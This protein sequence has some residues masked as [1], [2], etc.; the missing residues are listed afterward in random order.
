[1]EALDIQE[2]AEKWKEMLTKLLQPHPKNPNES[3]LTRKVNKQ[4]LGTLYSDLEELRGLT[5]SGMLIVEQ[6]SNQVDQ[7]KK[8]PGQEQEIQ[9]REK[10][11][12][13]FKK[14]VTRN[15]AIFYRDWQV[16]NNL[17]GGPTS[18][19]E[20][21]PYLAKMLRL[22]SE[23]SMAIKMANQVFR[24]QYDV[25]RDA[26]LQE[27]PPKLRSCAR[28]IL[29]VAMSWNLPLELVMRCLEEKTVKDSITEKDKIKYVLKQENSP[30]KEF[31]DQIDY[32]GT[33][34]ELE[35]LKLLVGYI[36]KN[37]DTVNQYA[38][39]QNKDV[40]DL[41][42]GEAVECMSYMASM[43]K[44]N[45]IVVEAVRAYAD[46]EAP[47]MIGALKELFEDPGLYPERAVHTVLA[48]L[49][50][51]QN[52][53]E[54]SEDEAGKIGDF[55]TFIRST[56][57]TI[58]VGNIDKVSGSLDVL[59]EPML[60]NMINEV[61]TEA[62]A[63]ELMR[64]LLMPPKDQ[65]DNLENKVG[66]ALTDLFVN[67][68]LTA[69]E[70]FEVYYLSKIGGGNSF[71]LGLKAIDI[72]NNHEYVELAGDLQIRKIS[73]FINIAG[74]NIG[75]LKNLFKDLQ[76]SDEFLVELENFAQLSE[77][78]GMSFARRVIHK[79]FT[80][81][82]EF[83]GWMAVG[84]SPIAYAGYKGYLKVRMSNIA[85]FASMDVKALEAYARQHNLPVSQAKQFK[86]A[87]RDVLTQ[88]RWA[89]HRL[90]PWRTAVNIKERARSVVLVRAARQ[91]ELTEIAKSLR[92]PVK[93]GVPRVPRLQFGITAYK[94][95]RDV[96]NMLSPLAEDT[97]Q[98]RAALKE[99]GYTHVD[100]AMSDLW[101]TQNVGGLQR[102]VGMARRPESVARHARVFESPNVRI[103]EA[104]K[105]LM[106]TL[107]N[108][109]TRFNGRTI[110]WNSINV[111]H[112][113]E[114]TGDLVEAGSYGAVKNAKGEWRLWSITDLKRKIAILD[115]AG[116]HR[117][118]YRFLLKE[119]WCGRELA[120][121]IDTPA[122][123]TRVFPRL[124]QLGDEATEAV[125][126]ITDPKALARRIEVVSDMD[127][128]V[129]RSH[130]LEDCL[131][132]RLFREA[133]EH[134]DEAARL[135][136]AAK[137][138]QR[139]KLLKIVGLTVLLDGIFIAL[140]E[141]RILEMTKLGEL[142]AARI[143]KGKR[144][145]LIWTGSGGLLLIASPTGWVVVPLVGGAA[146][147]DHLFEFAVSMD[148]AS[149]N[150]FMK[151]HTGDLI[152][153]I[154][155][156]SKDSISWVDPAL[157]GTG[158]S[159]NDTKL[160]RAR[161]ALEAYL[162]KT[163]KPDHSPK[164]YKE[165]EEWFDGLG[166]K[167]Q[168]SHIEKHGSREAVIADHYFEGLAL[169]TKLWVE[170]KFE[171]FQY[172]L[173]NNEKLQPSEH[174]R[175]AEAYA[176]LLQLREEKG[177]SKIP[178]E[179]TP[180][181]VEYMDLS[182]LSLDKDDPTYWEKIDELID[183][184]HRFELATARAR[185]ASLKEA[186]PEEAKN[187]ARQILKDRLKH[188]MLLADGFTTA[189]YNE[190]LGNVIRIELRRQFEAMLE[191]LIVELQ[192]GT[193]SLDEIDQYL[194]E[195][196][197]EIFQKSPEE[198]FADAKPHKMVSR[199]I[200][201]RTYVVPVDKNGKLVSLEDPEFN[202]VKAAILHPSYEKKRVTLV[203]DPA[204]ELWRSL[205]NRSKPDFRRS[206]KEADEMVTRAEDI[207]NEKYGI[208]SSRNAV[209]SIFE[210]S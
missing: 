175:R 72:L 81:W 194:R 165:A 189:R 144:E 57:A 206:Q 199:K 116:F 139:S 118:E 2:D 126:S 95:A 109:A 147:A 190:T 48:P 177:D 115:S 138:A 101:R 49:L 68:K 153:G 31:L 140:N 202:W 34:R 186:R 50:D 136:K 73:Q 107:D 24:M 108:G 151:M 12:T 102:T 58:S 13:A 156:L 32:I 105:A 23:E 142:E 120:E 166:K 154:S 171:Y 103:S 1:M 149:D 179:V 141:A 146:Y 67:K 97:D 137:L 28:E 25:A 99:A 18:D 148:K 185:F 192:D 128:P 10:E 78:A 43:S 91:T 135:Q 76:F 130:Q 184:F 188:A 205:K 6:L 35:G 209:S 196:V 125:E 84:H 208:D 5:W 7:L 17:W 174:I 80:L 183:T 155:K 63:E 127:D 70:V 56:E 200:N 158:I 157:L 27:T 88:H 47:D 39:S 169:I 36:A 124:A 150:E 89:E 94:D 66:D 33:E 87:L 15:F 93:Y 74:S 168:Q 77:E 119:G 159:E 19:V 71:T 92:N 29:I 41:S 60:N 207:H 178:C 145:S 37:L 44:V 82:Q 193:R 98:L 110:N 111:A 143:L 9:K 11:L 210:T 69:R 55:M 90:V 8:Q 113:V 21:P 79:Y 52:S 198:L 191:P 173:G 160:W 163:S 122:S 26:G 180:G 164:K 112:G 42:I 176:K 59:E 106:E 131:N 16:Y 85:H 203:E 104:R 197:K 38:K 14:E 86:Q 46:G 4:R 117:D 53:E 22:T 62:M 45:D 30:F 152:A 65:R 133:V 187:T 51:L 182:V 96:V 121:L 3:P 129:A 100:E 75:E 114:P 172:S 195:K 181:K 167:T 201:E 132:H 162:F 64:K 83:P 123:S 20:M 204:K 161:S 40:N 54:I 61:C 134:S 170:K